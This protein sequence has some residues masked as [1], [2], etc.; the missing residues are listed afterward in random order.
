MAGPSSAVDVH[1]AVAVAASGHDLRWP[2]RRTEPLC[3]GA[4]A[5]AAAGAEEG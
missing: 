1:A 4:A 2:W 3:S 5:A